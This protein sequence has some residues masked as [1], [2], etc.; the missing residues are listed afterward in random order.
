M[1][2]RLA[3]SAETR[4]GLLGLMTN[5]SCLQAPE[6]ALVE[7]ENVVCRRAGSVET[8][9]GIVPLVAS[10]ANQPVWGLST[11][12]ADY[13]VCTNGSTFAWYTSGGAAVQF[14]DPVL[15]VATDLQPLRRDV[16]TRS[17]LRGNTYLPADSGVFRLDA[18]P[19]FLQAGLPPYVFELANALT[20]AGAWLPTAERV[21]YR[22][23]TKDDR[24]NK[25]VVRSLPTGA[26]TVTNNSG[27]DRATQLTLQYANLFQGLFTSVEVYRTRNFS[28]SITVDDEM[29]LVAE[30]D[31]TAFT[32]S[33]VVYS[34]VFTDLTL[35]AERGATLYTSPSLG[36]IAEQNEMPPAAACAASYKQAL[37]FGNVRG[38]QRVV[39][40]SRVSASGLAGSATG[41]GLRT[42]AGDTTIG[43]N[44]I[45]NMTSVVGI[46]R[47]MVTL[48]S[49]FP[50]T[51]YVTNISGTTITMSQ[52]ATSS[53]VGGSR[54]FADAI[55]SPEGIWMNALSVEFLQ[56]FLVS[57]ASG[58]I[59]AYSI[60]PPKG[61]Y[62]NTYV[63][64]TI[65]RAQ[66]G[67]DIRATHGSEYDP[68]LPDYL[69]ADGLEYDQDE[70]PGAL[71]WSKTNEPEH[72]R[73]VNYAFVGDSAK[74]IL[75][76]APTRDALYVLKEDGIWRLTGV[77]G[78]W[79]IDPFDPT[80]YVMLPT[81]V[82]PINGRVYFLGNNGVVRFGDDGLELVSQAV[83]DL[84]KPVVDQLRASFLSTGLYELDGVIGG[85]SGVFDREDEYTLA[86][87]AGTSA[88]VYNEWT[89]GWTTFRYTDLVETVRAIWTYD[90]QGRAAYAIGNAIYGTRL[91]TDAQ[92]G[93]LASPLAANDG[94]T[95]V[96]ATLWTEASGAVTLS[97][98]VTALED[99]IVQDRSGV[100][101][102]V[103]NDAIGSATVYVGGLTVSPGGAALEF[104]TGSCVLYRSIRAKV[105]PQPYAEAPMLPKRWR[106]FMG[107]FSSIDGPV[108]LRYAFNSSESTRDAASWDQESAR[109][110]LVDG[111]ARYTAGYAYAGYV[112]TAHARAW[113]LSGS[114]RWV[115]SHGTAR[116]DAIV[117]TS[118]QMDEASMNQE[119]VS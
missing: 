103:L 49:G 18:A 37:F 91:S 31:V 53:A 83:N 119:A 87:A 68:P 70:F 12:S 63:F 11:Q 33:G 107:A 4:A 14:A 21:A 109:L 104:A 86:R 30:I 94:E 34:Y 82:Q 40:S 113:M 9:D 47:G 23:V 28:T 95:A 5:V 56:R 16:W 79:Q 85:T 2:W 81:S 54:I 46:E 73:P 10:T 77:D 8:R 93:V 19:A 29:Q 50:E 89:R 7:A 102:R 114:I 80:T 65:S 59:Y 32:L 45:I 74:A 76:L 51:A 17:D 108:A 13:H 111:R 3:L 110:A 52:V 60:T 115:Q 88:L 41:V 101:W 26:V 15:G 69:A 72:V 24:G 1:A 22:I 38:P 84:V 90:R 43:L 42:Y 6:G 39:V 97:S 58:A 57:Y 55:R 48:V 75:G 36:G 92:L 25:L 66:G 67:Y 64:E 112:P 96:T 44:T 106:R 20:T 117:A 100:L 61:G 62:T 35:P 98:P 105:S 118:D 99:D 78:D 27:G 116:L 71:Y